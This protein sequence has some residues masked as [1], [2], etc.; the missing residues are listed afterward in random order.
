MN[1]L[2][3]INNGVNKIGEGVA[4]EVWIFTFNGNQYIV[5][6]EIEENQ[7]GKIVFDASP[8]ILKK[9]N[10][11]NSEITNFINNEYIFFKNKK[12]YIV[13]K[14]AIQMPNPTNEEHLEMIEK[15]RF[16]LFMKHDIV[17]L[18]GHLKNWAFF[19]GDF[20]SQKIAKIIDLDGLCYMKLPENNLDEIPFQGIDNDELD[21]L[22]FGWFNSGIYFNEGFHTTFKTFNQL[23]GNLYLCNEMRAFVYLIQNLSLQKKYTELRN[24]HKGAQLPEEFTKIVI[25]VKMSFHKEEFNLHQLLAQTEI[26]IHQFVDKFLKNHSIDLNY[27]NNNNVIKEYKDNNFVDFISSCGNYLLNKS[28]SYENRKIILYFICL[29]PMQTVNCSFYPEYFMSTS[30]KNSIIDKDFIN[31]LSNNLS[32][33]LLNFNKSNSETNPITATSK[34]P[35]NILIS[36]KTDDIINN[37]TIQTVLSG[38]SLKNIVDKRLLYG[39]LTLSSLFLLKTL[40]KKY[41]KNSSTFKRL[42]NIFGGRAK[43]SAQHLKFKKT[44]K[45]YS[46]HSKRSVLQITK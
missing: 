15:S 46:S 12:K 14:A 8:D 16:D 13:Q 6:K 35:E 39:A 28:I 36:H 4:H 23:L 26:E 30:L 25:K 29:N 18:D 41:I 24:I 45:C 40:Y 19:D 32:K 42:R 31:V 21:T 37:G 5:K 20:F 10:S 11:N 43:S 7:Y 2:S 3:V 34:R 44:R 38:K 27:K 1:A 9:L 17:S 22:G 33:N